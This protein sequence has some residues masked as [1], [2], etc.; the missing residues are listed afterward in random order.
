MNTAKLANELYNQCFDEFR[1][2]FHD[3]RSISY[4]TV[5]AEFLMY[6]MGGE[7]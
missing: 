6:L 5:H 7:L 1:W 3:M 4:Q 2:A